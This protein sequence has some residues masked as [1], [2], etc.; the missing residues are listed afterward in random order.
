MSIKIYLGC[1]F[2]GKTSELIGEY[3]RWA[4]IGDEPVMINYAF[5]NRYGEDEFV[6]SHNKKKVPCIK[7]LELNNINDNLLINKNVILINEGQFFPDLIDFCVKWC[8]KY[9]KHIVVGG[10]DGD[11][12][13]QAFGKILDLIPYANEVHKLRAFCSVCKNGTPA[14]FTKKIVFDNKQDII[15]IGGAEKYMPVCRYHYLN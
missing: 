11:Y 1:M 6:S 5:D 9:N 7:T 14:L 2:S 3:T 8:E 12:K 4:D 10:L 15:D 13:R